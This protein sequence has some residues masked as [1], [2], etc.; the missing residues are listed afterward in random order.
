MVSYD[1]EVD[2]RAPQCVDLV[3]AQ[4]AAKEHTTREIFKR[5]L[6]KLTI[7]ELRSCASEYRLPCGSRVMVPSP[8]DHIAF[9][10]IGFVAVSP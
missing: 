8:D 9:P 3:I 1:S 7:I 6:S 5:Y 4:R 2:E 10:S